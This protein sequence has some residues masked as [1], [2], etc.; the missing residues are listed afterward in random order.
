MDDK[1]FELESYFAAERDVKS[2]P[3]V[4]LMARIMADAQTH[5]PA[6][7][8]A[9]TPQPTMRPTMRPTVRRGVF[10][11]LLDAVGGWPSLAGMATATVAGVWIGFSQPAG[12][13]LVAEQLLGT[14]DMTYLVDL[15]PAFDTETEEG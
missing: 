8:V 6:A 12:L 13:D 4:E 14:S 9:Q 2:Q 3:S 1:D 11:G 7:Q 15:V 10:A 5:S